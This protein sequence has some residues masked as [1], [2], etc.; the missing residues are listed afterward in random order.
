MNITLAGYEHNAGGNLFGF[1]S[2]QM[3][4]VS[5]TG[6]LCTLSGTSVWTSSCHFQ[7]IHA[8]PGAT[9]S[10]SAYVNHSEGRHIG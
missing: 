6:N 3:N 2:V 10:A 4:S 7:A 5:F 8:P 9:I 1:H